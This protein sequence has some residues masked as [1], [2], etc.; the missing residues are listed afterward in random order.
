MDGKS[1]LK[2]LTLIGCTGADYSSLKNTQEITS[3]YQCLHL[4]IDGN[5]IGDGQT[6]LSLEPDFLRMDY[7]DG[8]DIKS[9][10]NNGWNGNLEITQSSCPLDQ[11][12]LLLKDDYNTVLIEDD[13]AADEN[14]SILNY[15]YSVL[16]SYSGRHE[17]QVQEERESY[18]E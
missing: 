9:L 7:F 15:T 16:Y 11:Q 3:L 8:M 18:A 13:K 17:S 12:A 6:I 14:E 10:R 2:S 1:P 5:P 4:E